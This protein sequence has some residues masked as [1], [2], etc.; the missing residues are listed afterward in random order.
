MPSDPTVVTEYTE[1]SSRPSIGAGRVALTVF[2]LLGTLILSG[3]AVAYLGAGTTSSKQRDV[4]RSTRRPAIALR[5]T[6]GRLVPGGGPVRFLYAIKDVSARARRLERTSATLASADGNVVESG[7]PVH[8]CRA[9]WFTIRNNV[10]AV[11]VLGAPASASGVV[12]VAMREIGGNQNACQGARLDITVNGSASRSIVH[13]AQSIDVATLGAPEIS[14]AS[15]GDNA[16]SLRWRAV[17]APVGLTAVRYAVS[18]DGL[19]AAGNCP[20]L[21]SPLRVTRCTDTGVT[22]G[23][24]RYTATAVW[25]TWSSASGVAGVQLMKPQVITFSSIAPSDAAVGGSYTVAA[26]GGGSGEPVA[27]SIGSDSG[28]VCSIA[29]TTVT[30]TGRGGCRLLANQAGGNG[31]GPAPQAQQLFYVA[32]SS[33]VVPFAANSP[34]LTPLPSNAPLDPHSSQIVANLVA[35]IK[36][37]WGHAALN[38]TSYSAPI[39]TVPTTQPTTNLIWDASCQGSNPLPGMSAAVRNVPIPANASPSVGTDGNIIIWQPGTDTEWEFWRTVYDPNTGRWSVCWG[40]RIDDVSQNLGIFPFPYGV[41]A[42]GLSFLASE[43]RISE[44]LAGHINHALTLAVPNPAA[45]EIS[46][47]ANRTDG[48]D[49]TPYDP[50]EGERFRLDPSLDLSTLNLSPGE[51]ILARAMQQYGLIVTDTSGLVSIDAE[52]PRPY[53]ANGGP[54]PY[55]QLFP[56]DMIHLPDIPWNDLEAVGSNYGMPSGAAVSRSAHR[57]H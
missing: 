30:F 44:L 34:W 43:I 47:P 20:S 33:Q 19:P 50:A 36:N 49:L 57:R 27:F 18:R 39:F 5:T 12:S 6:G 21:S 16:V 55:D 31:Y 3:A 35:Q 29:G 24:H 23:W 9:S 8:G 32:D 15:P 48:V 26:S 11:R 51:L 54:N 46:W 45:H 56:G 53:Q 1:D 10:R 38:T 13:R 17:A 42:S 14:S 41:S 4:G 28:S 7:V 52:D 22:T 40:G 2:V 25:R 37:G